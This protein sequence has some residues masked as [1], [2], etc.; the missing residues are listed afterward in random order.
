MSR[1]TDL[2]AQ[3]AES[4]P[5]LANDLRRETDVLTRRRPFG[6]NFE[7]HIP[8]TVQLPNRR[9]RRGDKVVFRAP[10]GELGTGLDSRTWIVTSV[11]GAGD[12]RLATLILPEPSEEP[13]TTTRKVADLLVVAEFRD[14]IY[15]GLQPSGT[16]VESGGERP[17][18]VVI[19]GENYHVLEALTFACSGAVDCIYIDPPY[20]SRDKQWKYNNDYVDSDDDYRHSKWLAMMERR[21]K[22]AKELLNPDDS[23][24][25]VTIDEREVLR[26]GLLLEQTF[27][28]ARI[29][30]VTSVISA[31]GAVRRGQFSRVEEHLFFVL[32]GAA[33]VR[34]CIH[35]MLP[36][37]DESE[38]EDEEESLDEAESGDDDVAA[39]AHEPIE[40]IGLRRREPSSIRGARPNQF[41]P[42]FVDAETGHIHSIGDAVPDG[43]DRSSVA[44]PTGTIALWPLRPDGTERLWG[45]TPEA[46]RKNWAEG[47]VRV[48]W[49]PNKKTGTVYYL[50][51]GT[52][53][54]IRAGEVTIAGRRPDGSVEG[55]Y[56]PDTDATT[57]PKRVWNMRSH[58]AETGGTNMLTRLIPGRRFEYP[59]SLYAVEDTLRFVVGHKPHA[60][61][62]D[63]FA[64]SGTTAHAVMRLNKQDGGRR[65]SIMLTN[66]EVSAAEA[67]ALE[68]KGLRPG[69]IE[70]EA[71]GV[72]EFLTKPRVRAAIT[73]MTP[74][75]QAV[76]GSY[77]STDEFPISDG[78]DE[79]AAFFDLTYED[80]ERVR[81]GVGFEAV[82]PLFWLRA[83]AEG[84]PISSPSDTFEV[85]DAYA[86]LFNVDSSSAF[87]AAVRAAD[88]VR[89]AYIVTE[90]ET[91]F[92]V[93]AAQLPGHVEAVRLYS[94]Y[95]DNFRI[96]ARD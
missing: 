32:F 6:L 85:T 62:L 86:I 20:N 52:I 43:V 15:P 49:K 65:R 60:L 53:A 80:P 13:I 55:F 74:E 61:V 36:R 92:Q 84:A 37:M 11:E 46:L 64:G 83:G 67:D 19:N 75:G 26:L 94:A 66:N 90:D 78:F 18:H 39:K 21:L 22:V 16:T 25:I 88:D 54:S 2:L 17:Y 69:D 68:E 93:V 82:A 40:W 48:N 96:A 7:R 51:S 4:N 57:P 45:L 24:L 76:K 73:G 10:R 29:Q 59:K 95:L 14:P 63:F 58:N 1:L 34:P 5:D 38:A 72:C 9:V 81:Y 87:V 44:V 91:Q 47:F 89:I 71:L 50:P 8:E 77:T 42:I 41:F 27:P 30:M 12:D 31:K 79:N 33:R 23:A 28:E 3:L 35:N 56:A 70:W